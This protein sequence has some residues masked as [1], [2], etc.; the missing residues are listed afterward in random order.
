MRLRNVKNAE[1]ILKE[2][3]YY[4]D[5][6]QLWKGQWK[7][8]FSQGPI[9]LEIGCGKGQFLIEMAK[10]NPDI[11]FLGMEYEESVLVRAIQK[12]NCE[13]LP[14]LR[15]LCWD[16]ARILEIFDH[17]I[18]VMYLNFSDP[19]PKKRHTKRRLTSSPFL[20]E[21]DFIFEG[22]PVI[23]QKTDNLTFFG[24]SLEEFS[25]NGYI[26][27]RICFDL[28]KE[29]SVCTEYEEKFRKE[30]NPIYF[31]HARKPILKKD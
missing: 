19:W 22:D 21:Y 10:K 26:L 17:E 24:F 27:D 13:D 25:K 31:V 2:S 5:D 1:D 18:S 23:L 4:V 6:P 9:H 20:K 7:K 28:A 14:N 3:H 30:G 12:A 11:C 8:L 29:E 15:F 16:A